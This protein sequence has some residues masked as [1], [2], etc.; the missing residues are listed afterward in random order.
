MI[1]PHDT[2]HQVVKAPLHAIFGLLVFLLTALFR[3][4][5]RMLRVQQF[6]ILNQIGIV[7]RCLA[8]E[9]IADLALRRGP[10][11]NG[12]DVGRLGLV[13]LLLQLLEARGWVRRDTYILVPPAPCDAEYSRNQTSHSI[14]SKD[15]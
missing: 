5:K 3:L 9:E 6:G 1:P 15:R 8:R 7:P 10:L 4:G 14:A 12:V 13:L 2:A 11:R